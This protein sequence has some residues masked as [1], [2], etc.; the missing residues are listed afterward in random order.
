MMNR[1][2]HARLW[3]AR[4]VLDANDRLLSSVVNAPPMLLGG[5][6]LI[7]T[8]CHFGPGLWRRGFAVRWDS[9]EDLQIEIP[10]IGDFR[11][12]VEGSSV[13]PAPGSALSIAANKMH[14]WHTPTGGFMLGMNVRALSPEGDLLVLPIRKGRNFHVAK[15]A[16][17]AP[18]L[19]SILRLCAA[20]SFS[21][22][23]NN[24][25]Q[26]WLNLLIMDV[27][28]SALDPDEL[29]CKPL[30]S[31]KCL[32]YAVVIRGVV[33][34]IEQKLGG[35]LHAEDL[36]R[37]AGISVR[38]LNR[39]FA[40]FKGESLHRFIVHQ[41]VLRARA[42]LERDPSL[43]IKSVAAECG[44]ADASHLGNAFRKNFFISPGRFVESLKK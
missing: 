44:F 11:F 35:P 1:K 4:G 38:H 22:F 12:E 34:R 30:A 32:R 25:L 36:A 2:S 20:G 28:S 40:Q 19:E 14:V 41:R 27:L 24:R 15:P 7:C 9:H 13:Q 23:D 31:G 6:K 18:S 16:V 5:M 43:P 37:E 42:L 8:Q 29:D 26:S 21:E 10:L 33:K 3:T 17:T 39:L